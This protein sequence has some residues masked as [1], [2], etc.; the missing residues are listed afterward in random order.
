MSCFTVSVNSRDFIS[1]PTKVAGG[2]LYI[3]FSSSDPLHYCLGYSNG[4]WG[5]GESPWNF[6]FF[7]FWKF[8]AKLNP[9][10]IPQD[11][12]RSLGLLEIPKAKNKDPWKFHIIFYSSPLENPLHLENR[13]LS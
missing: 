6:S 3:H 9:L 2:T 10:D 12:V 11:C 4:G 5:W 7:Y 13:E 8:K 1:S